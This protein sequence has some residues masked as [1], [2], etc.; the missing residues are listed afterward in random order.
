MKLRAIRIL[1]DFFLCLSFLLLIIPVKWLLS[2]LIA[3]ALHELFHILALKMCGFQIRLI[4]VGA[5]GAKIETDAEYGFRSMLCALAGPL[6][7]FLLLLFLRKIPMIALCGLFQSIAN[8]LPIY[9]LDG[10]RALRN[11]LLCFLPEDQVRRIHGTSETVIW[12][13]LL[14][15]SIYGFIKLHL[16]FLPLSTFVMLYLRKK[17]LAFKA[18]SEYNSVIAY[19]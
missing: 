19:K 17:Y 12:I 13:F 8:L 5:F 6:A 4:C 18:S 9:P 3:A 14:G 16:G 11:L 1:P 15:L 7:G 2:W 10:G